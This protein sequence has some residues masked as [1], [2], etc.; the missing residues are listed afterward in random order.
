MINKAKKLNDH[1]RQI[2]S[3]LEAGKTS[4][5]IAYFKRKLGIFKEEHDRKKAAIAA[6][7]IKEEQ[8]KKQR[9]ENKFEYKPAEVLAEEYRNEL[10]EKEQ[11]S[12]KTAKKLLRQMKVMV[13][14]Q[15]IFY[16]TVNSKKSFFIFD[17]YLPSYRLCIEIDGSSHDDKKD[18]DKRRDK[19]VKLH[20][21]NTMR[22]TVDEVY[23]EGFLQ[24][25]VSE[26][27]KNFKVEDTMTDKA[28]SLLDK[29]CKSVDSK[30]RKAKA[31][32]ES[33]IK[34]PRKKKVKKHAVKHV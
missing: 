8:Y 30:I 16:Y 34:R 18:K 26:Y 13:E 7:K 3:D 20:G 21:I 31:A 27:I 24:G 29:A 33:A 10:I 17:F 32:K 22:F 12:E 9:E 2:L 28:K 11:P 1:Y 19:I 25:K 6:K 15:Y 14:R 5:A 4:G 23:I